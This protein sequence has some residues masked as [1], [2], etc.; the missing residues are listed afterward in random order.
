MREE[1]LDNKSPSEAE[2]QETDTCNFNASVY[3]SEIEPNWAKLL[4]TLH[5]SLIYFGAGCEKFQWVW[6]SGVALRNTILSRGALRYVFVSLFPTRMLQ[7]LV[8]AWLTVACILLEL[9]VPFMLW[10]KQ[11]KPYAVI[12]GCLMHLAMSC[13]CGGL[14]VY[15]MVSWLCLI[16]SLDDEHV[17]AYLH[18]PKNFAIVALALLLAMTWVRQIEMIKYEPLPVFL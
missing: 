3:E 6:I 5:Y 16:S 9:A 12:A 15:T 4:I 13:L 14:G 11:T 10:S 1:A 2:K 17:N 8:C 18:D 7:L